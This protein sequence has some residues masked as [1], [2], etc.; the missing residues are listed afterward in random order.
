MSAGRACVSCVRCRFGLLVRSVRGRRT[1]RKIPSL[2]AAEHTCRR[3]EELTSHSPWR[4]KRCARHCEREHEEELAHIALI[5]SGV[6]SIAVVWRRE[7]C[8]PV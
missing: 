7:V 4:E 3:P 8:A 2:V 5:L 1:P 6:L